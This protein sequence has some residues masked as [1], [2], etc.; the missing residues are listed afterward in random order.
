MI[1]NKIEILRNQCMYR[2]KT[3][4][5]QVKYIAYGSKIF[6]FLKINEFDQLKKKI[7]SILS[8]MDFSALVGFTKCLVLL[9][10][11]I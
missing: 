10:K 8:S 11:N 4:D 1:K 3:I 2:F 6:T 7:S 5:K 9:T